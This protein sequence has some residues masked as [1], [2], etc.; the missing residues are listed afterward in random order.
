MTPPAA[1]A[2]HRPGTRFR[3]LLVALVAGLALPFLLLAGFAVWQAAQTERARYESQLLSTARALAIAVDRELGQAQARLETL[4]ALPTLRQGSLDAFAAIALQGLPTDASVVVYRADGVIRLVVT[5]AGVNASETGQPSR[6]GEFLRAA[7][8]PGGPRISPVLTATPSR[9]PRVLVVRPVQVAGEAHLLGLS[10]AANR[11]RRILE[12]QGLPPSWRAAVLDAELR[13]GARTHMEEEFIGRAAHP[14]IVA[15][16]GREA[17]G[18]LR[19]IRTMDG[20]LTVLAAARAPESGFAI[21]LAAPSETWWEQLRR[22][23]GL[24]ILLGVLVAQAGL[25]LALSLASRLIQALDRLGEAGAPATGIA[26]VDATAR[27]LA[28]A[29]SIRDA[30]LDALME[31][32]E[33][34]RLTLEAF[35]GGGDDWH[36]AE[37]RVVRSAGLL[38]LVGE[39]AHDA[40]PGWW[41]DRIHPDDRP[42]WYAARERLSAGDRLFEA[43]YRVRH[44]DGRWVHAWHRS[45][46]LRDARGAVTRLV[47]YVLDVSA[48][49][50]AR[51]QVA[52]VAREMDHRVKNSFA[53]VAGLAAA[54]AAEHPEAAAFAEELRDRL[55]AM[56]TAHDLSRLGAAGGATSL[57]ELARRL[58]RPHGAAV[59]VE[60]ADLPLAADDVQPL[61]LVLH[62]WL[63]NSVKHGALSRP[64]GQVAIRLAARDAMAELHWRESG[65]PP[66]MAPAE[67]GFGAEL[68]RATVE[69]QLGGQAE[70][71]WAPE[72]LRITLRWPA[73]SAAG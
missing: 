42:A 58:G 66:A 6:A 15:L 62:E 5:A 25:V 10:L 29:R 40:T 27:K 67:R 30:A 38:A 35:G 3:T 63:T 50:Q 31:N 24:T 13:V 9:Q 33:R 19:D 54:A 17:G 55:R 48:E 56:A 8:E 68:V 34:S 20:L 39:A 37:G 46:A 73:G 57:A 22:T 43:R 64:G 1:A 52:L 21:A 45:L 26:E 69:S 2:S 72:G 41:T 12:D 47:G 14:R 71:E 59:V 51:A 7:L 60:G 16:L 49:A 70:E 61:A 4:A 18:L 53:L 32:E 11:L 65:G 28:K 44:A 23:L 36:P